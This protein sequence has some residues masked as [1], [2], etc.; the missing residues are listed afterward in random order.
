MTQHGS[1]KLSEGQRQRLQLVLDLIQ[2]FES[3][4]SMEAAPV[5]VS[6]GYFMV[7]LR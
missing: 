3:P 5:A 6:V 4:L 1:D 7:R 2:G